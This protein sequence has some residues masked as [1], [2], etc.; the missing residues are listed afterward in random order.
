MIAYFDYSSTTY[1]KPKQVYKAIK[2]YKK[3]GVNIGR[4]KSECSSK[5]EEIIAET[6]EMLKKLVKADDGYKTI[7][8]PSA[9]YS[10]NLLIKGLDYTNIKNVYIYKYEHN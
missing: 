9:T 3:Y 8:Q 1:R 6:R 4:G 10:L 5:C 7:F 2:T